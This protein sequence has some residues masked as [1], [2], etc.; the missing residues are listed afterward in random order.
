MRGPNDTKRATTRADAPRAR[1]SSTVP[2][3]GSRHRSPPQRRSTTPRKRSNNTPAANPTSSPNGGTERLAPSPQG[4]CARRCQA[5]APSRADT[6]VHRNLRARRRSNASER[7]RNSATTRRCAR[8]SGSTHEAQQR[9]PLWD[10][11]A[12]ERLIRVL[13]LD[14]LQSEGRTTTWHDYAPSAGEIRGVEVRAM[15]ANPPQPREVALAVRTIALAST[16]PDT[17]SFQ[18]A[19]ERI[20]HDRCDGRDTDPAIA[21]TRL[22][23]PEG[24][25]VSEFASTRER[26]ARDRR[27]GAADRNRLRTDSGR[28][29]TQAWNDA[30]EEIVEEALRAALAC[31]IYTAPKRRTGAGNSTARAATVNTDEARHGGKS[32]MSDLIDPLAGI[33]WPGDTHFDRRCGTRSN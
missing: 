9:A 25:L 14:A 26:R 30:R 32:L 21:A 19:I 31:E 29:R 13:G 7:P 2:S 24:P 18:A 23:A 17:N 12:P 10:D 6:S 28:D 27:R 8:C 33:G 15:V 5:S 22:A 11:Y 16:Q 1:C 3:S 20:R 4:W